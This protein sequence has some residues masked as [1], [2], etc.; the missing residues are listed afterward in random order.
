[1][2]FGDDLHHPQMHFHF[3]NEISKYTKENMQAE[4]VGSH[5][6]HS[7][8]I[9]LISRPG[10]HIFTDASLDTHIDLTYVRHLSSPI[11]D[12]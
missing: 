8:L 3:T 1:M 12:I 9:N 6:S 2:G 11:A 10:C 5:F 7:S 4:S